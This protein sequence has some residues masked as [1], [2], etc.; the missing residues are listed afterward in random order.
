VEKVRVVVAN[1]PDGTLTLD[2][3]SFRVGCWGREEF[4]SDGVRL[5]VPVKV[6]KLVRFRV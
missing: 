1:P 4:V 2:A 3:P 5:T 6:W